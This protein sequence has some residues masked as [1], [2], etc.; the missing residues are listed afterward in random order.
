MPLFRQRWAWQGKVSRS[1]YALVGTIAF[2]LKIG[3]ER[4][5]AWRVFGYAGTWSFR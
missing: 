1:D 4:L 3:L 2:A 5:I